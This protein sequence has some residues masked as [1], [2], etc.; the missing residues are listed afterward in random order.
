MVQFGH[1]QVSTFVGVM[2]SRTFPALGFDPAPG[3]PAGRDSAGRV[4]LS[5]ARTLD[6]CGRQLT[7][8]NPAAWDG[9]AATAFRADLA[10][11]PRDLDRAARAHRAAGHALIDYAAALASMQG[12]A[13]G[14]EQEAA[15]RPEGDRARCPR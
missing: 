5:T 13:S 14:L 12:R 11:L 2:V 6:S 7:R 10:A 8:A 3:D 4:A 1:C 9:P 15:S